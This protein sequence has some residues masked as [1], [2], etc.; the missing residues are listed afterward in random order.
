MKS[1]EGE[2]GETETFSCQTSHDIRIHPPAIKHGN[3]TIKSKTD[4][5]MGK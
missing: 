4:A 5:L 3:E 1:W 2:T